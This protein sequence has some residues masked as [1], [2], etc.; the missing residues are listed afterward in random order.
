MTHRRWAKEEDVILRENYFTLGSGKLGSMLNRSRES[1]QSRASILG[2][3]NKA[4]VDL[5]AG[6]RFGK[7]TVVRK[8]KKKYDRGDGRYGSLYV[9]HCDCGGEPTAVRRTNLTSGCSTSCGCGTTE[10]TQDALRKSPGLVSY[11]RKYK[12]CEDGAINR[13]LPFDLTLE[14]HTAIIIQPCTYCGSEP[15]P[16]NA[17]ISSGGKIRGSARNIVT[18]SIERA[19]IKANGI[20]R[21]DNSESVGYTLENSVPCCGICNGMKN[22]HTELNFLGHV[23]KIVNF[24]QS[25]RKLR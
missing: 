3:K 8:S 12:I 10:A 13:G 23:K 21:K 11:N 15:K 7:L 18:E 25:T 17:Y 2:V 1:V 22:D 24:Q 14:Q 16:F 5:Q 4:R 6:R 19:W 9:C 20:D